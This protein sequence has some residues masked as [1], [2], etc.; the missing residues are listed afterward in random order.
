VKF[1]ILL[2]APDV[3]GEPER[4][5]AELLEQ[6]VAA[7]KLGYDS[8][9]VTEH[10]SRFGVV[11]SPAVLLAALAMKTSHIRL[12]SMAAILPYHRPLHVAE[13]Y[14]LVD[15]L[16]GGR[17]ELGVG[18]G[19]LASELDLHGVDPEQSR[20]AFWESL[21]MVQESWGAD[22][23]AGSR[24]L[25]RPLQ[26]PVPIW[27]AANSLETAR[28]AAGLGLRIATSPAG[29][30]LMDYRRNMIAIRA[31]LEA[32]GHSPTEMQ[33]PLSTFDMYIAPSVAQARLEFSEP[34]FTMHR[35]MCE[36]GRRSLAAPSAEALA[37][38]AEALGTSLVTDPAGAV[39][40][41]R[42]LEASTG[43]AHFVAATAQGGLEHELVLSSMTLFATEV[44]AVLRAD[45]DDREHS[46]A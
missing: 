42:E 45:A 3:S 11:G 19:N 12:G 33:F 44:M 25:P 4:D 24:S 40:Y 36:S 34:A 23:S 35:L 43:L 5:F 10:H 1:G 18:R 2:I 8:I 9:W 13:S 32:A 29:G 6:A 16:S 7:E 46:P 14:A 37:R 39:S 41:L 17:L 28:R 31:M 15:V 20:E 21:A 22:A 30:D 38:R 27:V 26:D